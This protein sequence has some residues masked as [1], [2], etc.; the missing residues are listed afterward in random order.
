VLEVRTQAG[1]LTVGASLEP[2]A[3]AADGG[4]EPETVPY[5]LLISTMPL[6]ALVAL[7]ADAPDAVRQ[8]A[9]KLRATHLWYLDVAL[10]RPARQPF[11]WIYVPEDLYPFYRVGCYSHF[12][13]EMAPTGAACLYVELV[14]RREPVLA[15]VLP[16]VVDGLVSMG[17]LEC[18]EDVLF[19]RKRLL[20]P[21]YVIFD[22]HALPSLE[23]VQGW[24]R[25]K[26]VLSIGRYGGWGYSS[27][28]DALRFGQ[29]AA[30]QA[31]R[32]LS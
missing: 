14:S 23:L 28:A 1:E 31:M 15:E 20:D 4:L 21:A 16:G 12:S 3:R 7:I 13:P 9:K 11:H 18:A 8:A 32:L 10:R 17:V 29:D 26:R 5:E 22:Q 6:P 24:L 27:M 19:A 30:A 25:S 2:S